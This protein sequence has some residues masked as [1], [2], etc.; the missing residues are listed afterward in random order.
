MTN[1]KQTLNIDGFIQYA[2]NTG[3]Y[4]NQQLRDITDSLLRLEADMAK[5]SWRENG[6]YSHKYIHTNLRDCCQK[7]QVYMMTLGLSQ[8]AA[9][10]AA[11]DFAVW[12]DA[13]VD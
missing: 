12:M 10:E 9:V 7:L 4:N 8:A 6:L 1:M 5:L 3:K 13:C 2:A 11:N